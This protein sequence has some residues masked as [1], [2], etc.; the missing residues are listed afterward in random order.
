MEAFTNLLGFS[1]Q[2]RPHNLPS[3][4]GR[5]DVDE[6]TFCSS[7]TIKIPTF[8][9]RPGTTENTANMVDYAR[10]LY[11]N[12]NA[13]ASEQEMA[14]AVFKEAAARDHV[15]AM[16]EL[17][18][19]YTERINTPSYFYQPHNQQQATYYKDCAVARLTQDSAEFILSQQQGTEVNGV[20]GSVNP[21]SELYAACEV[22]LHNQEIVAKLPNELWHTIMHLSLTERRQLAATCR[23]LREIV[24]KAP[25][26]SF[27]S[28][29]LSTLTQSEEMAFCQYLKNLSGSGLSIKITG[30]PYQIQ[31]QFDRAFSLFCETLSSNKNIKALK[32]NVSECGIDSADASNLAKLTQLSSLNISWNEIG[33]AGAQALTPLTQLSSLDITDNKIGDAGA[34]A[35]TPLTQLSSLDISWNRIGDAGAQALACL[36]QLSSL[37]IYMNEIGAE[38]AQALAY[39]TQLSSLDISKNNIRDAG[40]QALARLTQLSSLDIRGNVIGAAGAQ[41]LTEALPQLRSFNGKRLG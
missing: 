31:H 38:G 2:R 16:Y 1:S 33:A 8:D 29:D 5:S 36:T 9:P 17:T 7:E 35:L 39:L 24:R 34:Q 21:L 4:N 41:A 19:I 30:Y 23:T 40:A 25:P 22:V 18:V 20:E 27:I 10:S 12:P 32:L 28:L 14:V 26:P 15:G 11:R 13:T 6:T 3:I 37:N